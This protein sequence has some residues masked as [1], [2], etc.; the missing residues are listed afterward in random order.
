[1]REAHNMKL[2]HNFNK[3]GTIRKNASVKSSWMEKSN[4]IH[5][6]YVMLYYII[7]FTN[8]KKSRYY[9]KKK[10][11]QHC[12]VSQRVM[13]CIVKFKTKMIFATKNNENVYLM[14]PEIN[15]KIKAKQPVIYA[16]FFNQ[17]LLLEQYHL[18][19]KNQRK[20]TRL[21]KKTDWVTWTS[22]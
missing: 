11:I 1:M 21:T 13:V 12:V 4:Q 14:H 7:V 16:C 17:T 15:R 9:T 22:T 6:K 18:S 8:H 10:I 20:P 2:T 19:R 5:R 3:N